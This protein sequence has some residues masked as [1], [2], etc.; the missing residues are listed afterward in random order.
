MFA[1][2]T[3]VLVRYI[4]RDDEQQTQDATAFIDALT[5]EEPAFVSVVVLCELCWVLRSTYGA[6]RTECADAIDAI[7]EVPEFEFEDLDLCTLAVR[8]Y[9]LGLADFSDY[10]IR[11]TAAHARCIGVKTFDKRALREPGFF[12]VRA[13]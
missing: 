8:A 11:E 3:N 12:P 1:L 6:G 7:L 4:V 2:D 10:I 9:R 13:R 5:P